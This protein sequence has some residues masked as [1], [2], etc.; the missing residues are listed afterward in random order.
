MNSMV[1]CLIDCLYIRTRSKN[2]VFLFSIQLDQRVVGVG[3]Q[4]LGFVFENFFFRLLFIAKT[5]VFVVR[6]SESQVDFV[7]FNY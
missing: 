4:S 7:F 2:I 5:K 1:A 3:G 6:E